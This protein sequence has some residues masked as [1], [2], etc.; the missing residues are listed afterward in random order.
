MGKTRKILVHTLRDVLSI[1]NVPQLHT[2]KKRR[3]HEWGLRY[4]V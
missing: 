4:D 1:I 3:S 2:F